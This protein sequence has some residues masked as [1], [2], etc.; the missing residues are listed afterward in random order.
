MSLQFSIT[1]VVA[2][3]MFQACAAPPPR[4]LTAPTEEAAIELNYGYG[5]LYSTIDSESDVA[6]VLII[7]NPDDR[8]ADLLREIAEFAQQA[9]DEL[10]AFA[11]DDDSLGFDKDGLPAVETYT[12]RAIERSTAG[13]VLRDGGRDFEF[14]ILLTQYQALDYIM[15]TASTLSRVDNNDMRSQWLDDLAEDAESLHSRV[16]ELL[17][18]PYVQTDRDE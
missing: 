11:D 6:K 8:V 16:L 12:R 10:R 17:K 15:H 5:L 9:R 1:I 3:M 7:K 14:T 2:C 13:Q 4:A 18:T